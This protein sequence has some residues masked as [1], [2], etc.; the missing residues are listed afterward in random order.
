MA[1]YDAYDISDYLEEYIEDS[2]LLKILATDLAMNQQKFDNLAESAIA[3]TDVLENSNK[4]SYEYI[5]GLEKM[6]RAIAGA[7]GVELAEEWEQT[8]ADLIERFVK[9]EEGAFEELQQ[10]IIEGLTLNNAQSSIIKSIETQLPKAAGEAVELTQ[11]ELSGL[12]SMSNEK[13]DQV[14]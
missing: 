14:A 6:R 11:K 5:T 4:G 1:L 10:T 3:F 9:G 8:H 13:L 12:N 7:F 2:T